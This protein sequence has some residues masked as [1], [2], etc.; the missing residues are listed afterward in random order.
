MCIK[1]LKMNTRSFRYILPL[2]VILL[3][4]HVFFVTSCKKDENPPPPEK[5]TGKIAFKF[6]H[7]ID[8]KPI[9]YDTM[10]YM[11]AA[12]NHYL[13]NEIQWFISDVAIHKGND[14][15][16]LDVWEDIH[17]VDTDIEN[18][19]T[20][21]L[22]DDIQPG[23]YDSISFTFGIC[24]TKNKSLMF[25]NPPESLMFW[26]ELLGGGYHYMKL[27]GKWLDTLNHISPFNFHLGIGQ[28]YYSFPDSIERYVQNYFRVRLP[29]SAFEVNEDETKTFTIVMNVENW[30]QNPNVFD[31]NYWGGDIMQNQD[32]MHAACQNGWDVFTLE[33]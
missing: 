9:Q 21:T 28:I 32:A 33:K 6:A 1:I 5:Q 13:V 26:P 25:V 19:W 12:G 29:N 20:F 17:Y 24:E 16:L 22:K 2:L 31:F 30:F 4:G 23:T 8:G 18:T 7:R 3:A 14:S 15:T 10:K 11:N 27:N